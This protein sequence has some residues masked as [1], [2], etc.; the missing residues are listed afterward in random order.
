M[1]PVIRL[2]AAHELYAEFLAYNPLP[3]QPLWG[4]IPS[5]HGFLEHARVGLLFLEI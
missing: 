1:L 4:L 3:E 5:P 2:I